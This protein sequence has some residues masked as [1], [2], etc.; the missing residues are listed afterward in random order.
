MVGEK[1]EKSPSQSEGYLPQGGSQGVRDKRP[2]WA[3]TKGLSQ[4]PAW[5][6]LCLLILSQTKPSC[7]SEL[8]SA[9]LNLFFFRICQQISSKYSSTLNK[10]LCKYTLCTDYGPLV[11]THPPFST[12]R[13][14]LVL[15]NL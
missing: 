7:F 4:K 9:N 12:I 5:T 6:S 15:I 14:V 13:F 3:Q 8:G 1:S 2:Y 11:N 10:T